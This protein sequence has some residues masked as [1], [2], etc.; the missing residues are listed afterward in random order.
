M[1]YVGVAR[2]LEAEMPCDDVRHRLGLD[3]DRTSVE[4]SARRPPVNLVG[5]Q[6]AEKN[7]RHL[8]AK[9]TEPAGSVQFLVD[10]NS[11]FPGLTTV[12]SGETGC[13]RRERFEV[14]AYAVAAGILDE[15]LQPFGSPAAVEPRELP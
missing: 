12:D 13:G 15:A 1:G 7:M 6:M 3:L 5:T 8:M 4:M 9:N 14:D 11:R 2:A 10:G